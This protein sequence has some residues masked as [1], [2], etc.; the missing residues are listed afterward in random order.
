MNGT[1]ATEKADN[2]LK[3]ETKGSNVPSIVELAVSGSLTPTADN[4]EQHTQVL[5][6]EA[7]PQVVPIPAALPMLAAAV[8][9]LGFAGWRRKRA[10]A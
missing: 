3:H 10:A 5:S 2:A 9:G 1:N 7:D 6:N 8:A 4:G